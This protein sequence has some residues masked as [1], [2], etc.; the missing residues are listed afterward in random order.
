MTTEAQSEFHE[1]Y[2]QTWIEPDPKTRRTNIDRVW[3][4]DGRMVISPIGLTVQGLDDLDKHI[5][6]VHEEN[7]AGKGL[8]F[9]YDQQAEAGDALLLRWSMLTPDGGTAGRG[10]DMVFRD[11]DGRVTT[12]YMFMGVD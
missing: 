4:A 11:A 3:S 2:L 1:D 8:R 6:R 9:V 7:I 10:V 5:A 12:V